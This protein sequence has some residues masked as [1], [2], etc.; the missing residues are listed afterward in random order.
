MKV[1]INTIVIV[2]CILSFIYLQW[3]RSIEVCNTQ[4]ETGNDYCRQ[5]I[6]LIANKVWVCNQEKFGYDVIQKCIDNSFGNI[7]FSY[8]LKRPNKLS[9]KVY[10]N[11]IEYWKGT[12][13]FTVHFKQKGENNKYNIIDNP[14][15]F[16]MTIE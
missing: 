16:V 7:R 14:D 13:A 2:A 3:G 8:D 5:N 9:I 12:P 10:T 15:K 11:K 1:K 4:V 6:T